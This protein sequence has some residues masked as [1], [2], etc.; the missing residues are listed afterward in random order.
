MNEMEGDYLLDRGNSSLFRAF[1]NCRSYHRERFGNGI[2][3]LVR[4]RNRYVPIRICEIEPDINDEVVKRTDYINEDSLLHDDEIEEISEKVKEFLEKNHLSVF[5][6]LR[7]S[8]ACLSI[9]GQSTSASTVLKRGK[10][11]LLRMSERARGCT[12]DAAA[13]SFFS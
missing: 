2:G 9:T 7:T 10:L 6:A 1:G 11:L 8:D 3:R 5:P 13:A 4:S 12:R